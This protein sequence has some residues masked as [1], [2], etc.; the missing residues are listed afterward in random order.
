M[1][2]SRS[3]D[4]KIDLSRKTTEIWN[5][6]PYIFITRFYTYLPFGFI[7]KYF[8]IVY[9]F[10]ALDFSREKLPRVFK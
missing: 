10:C 4:I 5:E 3:K 9:I 2:L 8:L 7:A 1:L 6:E